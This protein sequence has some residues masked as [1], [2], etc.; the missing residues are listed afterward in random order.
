MFALAGVRALAQ[1]NVDGPSHPETQ[2][3]SAQQNNTQAKSQQKPD[4]VTTT[5]IVHGELKDEY[6]SDSGSNASLD[7]T[8]LKEL[9]L[10]VT[11]VTSALIND[12]IARSLSDV[13]K[14]DASV[15]E[16]YAPVGY[17][18]DYEILGFPIDLATG[19]QINGLTIA[20]EQDVPL[21]NKQ[22]VEI[23]K[24]IAGVESGVASAGGVIDYAT[25]EPSAGLHPSIDL[26]TDHRGSSYGA[27]EFLAPGA[28]GGS[29]VLIT[30]VAEDIHT[31]VQGANGWRGM[32]AANGRW[33][34]GAKTQLM[35]DFEYQHKVERSEAG[36][37]LLGGTI[38]PSPVYPSVM[39]G[40]QS[41]SK[42]NTFD[43]F[44]ASARLQRDLAANWNLHLSGSYSHSLIDDNVIWPYG[45]ALDASGNSLCA[46]AVPNANFFCPDGSYE[47][48]D[49]RSPGEL[50]IDAVG[51]ALVLGHFSTGK[52]SHDAWLAAGLGSIARWT[53]RRA[54]FIRRSEPRISFSRTSLMRRRPLTSKLD[55]QRWPISITRLRASCRSVHTCRGESCCRLGAGLRMYRISTTA[56]RVRCGCR[57]TRPATLR[58]GT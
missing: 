4:R 38:V 55:Q 57:S 51:E 18:S 16:D 48:Y 45:P 5:V 9:P 20:G 21:E 26:G 52:I 42:P 7:N 13:V 10:A 43:T 32:G 24:G 19:L 22:R 12:Q 25:K 58:C 8:P 41:W 2:E 29:G 31:Y 54:L 17:Y 33:Q 14:N 30:A 11:D 50:R 34:L 39:L 6:L 1:S 3:A 23:V 36:Y 15:S 35:T 47:I 49:Y 40:F 27:V 53:F 37:Q 56:T 44:N 46:A 28:R